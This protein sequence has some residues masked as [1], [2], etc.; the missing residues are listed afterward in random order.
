[1]IW[2]LRSLTKQCGP[3]IQCWASSLDSKLMLRPQCIFLPNTFFFYCQ[4]QCVGFYSCLDHNR[5]YLLL[6][7]WQFIV[8]FCSFS[9][10][11]KRSC[12][13]PLIIF[14]GVL[15]AY[16]L[17]KRRFYH[18]LWSF[19]LQSTVLPMFQP[20]FVFIWLSLVFFLNYFWKLATWKK[21]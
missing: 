18:F 6:S 4:T 19:V 7:F 11:K 16:A 17:Q 15:L 13:N 14:D 3:C 10:N 21:G 8:S 1:M 20:K 5:E 12:R 9:K 2:S